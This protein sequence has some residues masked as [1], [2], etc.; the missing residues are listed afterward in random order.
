MAFYVLPSVAAR[1]DKLLDEEAYGLWHWDIVREVY[2]LQEELK[3]MKTLVEKC[4]GQRQNKRLIPFLDQI[5]KLGDEAKDVFESLVDLKIKGDIPNVLRR[6]IC[7][8]KETR[9]LEMIEGFTSEIIYLERLFIRLRYHEESKLWLSDSEPDHPH[10]FVEVNVVGLEDVIR[11]LVSVLVDDEWKWCRVVSIW[12][13]GGL[14]K[15]ALAKKIYH[16]SKVRNN[17]D[18][19]AWAYVSQKWQRRNVWETILVGLNKFDEGDRGQGDDKVAAKLFKFLKEHKCLVILDNITNVEAWDSVKAALPRNL[20]TSSRIL[21]TCHNKEV[22]D[23]DAALKLIYSHELQPLNRATSLELFQNIAFPGK[24]LTGIKPVTKGIHSTYSLN[25]SQYKLPIEMDQMIGGCEG[26]PVAIVT[27]GG[28][29][30]AKLTKAEKQRM[31]TKWTKSG[32]GVVNLMA[33]SYEDL[34]TYLKPCLLYLSLFPEGYQISVVKLIQ[35]WVADEVI[36]QAMQGHPQYALNG[37]EIWMEDVAEYCLLELVE[38]CMIQVGERDA[39]SK[40]KTCYLDNMIREMCLQ[41]AKREDFVHTIDHTSQVVGYHVFTAERLA[42]HEYNDIKGIKPHDNLRSLFFFNVIL[43]DELLFRSLH[44]S[45]DIYSTKNRP[46]RSTLLLLRR[47]IRK[48]QRIW[49]Y[50]I[51]NFRSLRVLEFEGTEIFVGGELPSNIGKLTDLRYLSL[52]NASYVS[53]LPS[54]LGNLTRLQTLNLGMD[55]KFTVYVPDVIL[56]LESLRHLYLPKKCHEKTKLSLNTLRYLQTLVNFNTKNCCVEDVFSMTNLRELRI[57]GDFTLEGV[58]ENLDWNLRIVSTA[59]LRCLSIWSPDLRQIDPKHLEF[60]LLNCQNIRELTLTVAM[61]EL[62]A[63]HQFSSKITYLYLSESG[64]DGDPMP[65][66]EKLRN[67]K[68]L[69]LHKAFTGKKISCSSQGFPQ[70]DSLKLIENSNLVEWTV[71]KNSMP[72]LHQLE[73]VDCRK[74]KMLPCGL[75]L[76]ETLRELKIERMPKAFKDRLMLKGGED[77]CKFQ[78]ISSI[79]CQNCH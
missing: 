72:K 20:E 34:P 69:G 5:R 6:C 12:G 45:D 37:G 31:F 32:P 77:F 74:L 22:L 67:L 59:N 4:S 70:L 79:I 17:F 51:N 19:F 35:L 54:T 49:R 26:L 71:A 18:W 15:T 13:K 21:I 7:L 66:L 10:N 11:K 44:R 60:L 78:Y 14:G 57:S 65:I 46:W 52:Q 24:Q 68:V 43:S 55:S 47:V 1:I 16:H 9:M 38:R 28:I 62:P 50:L 76:I 61:K 30:A 42:I 27:L 41:E 40:I 8:W 56:R 25:S 36:V 63:Y 29:F 23:S 33:L 2:L 53:K 58:D 73:I 64:L 48:F 3:R 39:N 75:R